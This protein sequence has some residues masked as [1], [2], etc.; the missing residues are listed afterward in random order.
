MLRSLGPEYVVWDKAAEI[1][2]E[3]RAATV[4]SAKVLRW[5]ETD[6]VTDDGTVVA[7]VRK[8][9]YVRERRKVAQSSHR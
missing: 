4:G 8:Q 5:F 9:L 7:R 1:L 3:L 2:T 6:I